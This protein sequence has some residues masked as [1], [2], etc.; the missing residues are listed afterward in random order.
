MRPEPLGEPI[1]CEFDIE[2]GH[3]RVHYKNNCC[4]GPGGHIE[5]TGGVL[6]REFPTNIEQKQQRG[7]TQ[8]PDNHK[9]IQPCPSNLDF[10][11]VLEASSYTSGEDRAVDLSL[12]WRNGERTASEL[13][14]LRTDML[15]QLSNVGESWGE[16][17]GDD[18]WLQP[19]DAA[20]GKKT[21]ARTVSDARSW[22]WEALKKIREFRDESTAWK[23]KNNPTNLQQQERTEG[24]DDGSPHAAAVSL[25]GAT[26]K[27]QQTKLQHHTDSK[28]ATEFEKWPKRPA[29]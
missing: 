14:E 29:E 17:N 23:P 24:A 9:F 18:G 2:T 28:T 8:I 12:D 15:A 7:P 11:G 27:Q 19:D 26:P 21:I 1:R 5:Q 4:P 10:P 16:A 25:T 22:G 13:E 20:E 3:R 6:H